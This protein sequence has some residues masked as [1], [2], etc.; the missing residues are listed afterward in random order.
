MTIVQ[1]KTELLSMNTRFV[2]QDDGTYLPQTTSEDFS[3]CIAF[4][5]I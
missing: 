3:S 4:S 2:K 1:S 5:G